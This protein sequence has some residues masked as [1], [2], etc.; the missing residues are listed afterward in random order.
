MPPLGTW[1]ATQ[2]CALTGNR[3]GDLSVRRL[4]LKSSE[5]QQPGQGQDSLVPATPTLSSNVSTS[6]KARLCLG[7][8]DQGERGDAGWRLDA[9]YPKLTLTLQMWRE[10]EGEAEVPLLPQRDS[11]HDLPPSL[12]PIHS[13]HLSFKN[14]CI[15]GFPD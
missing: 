4:A 1:Q 12:N 14:L 6:K 8:Q 7:G 3:T 5:P 13:H 15:S 9:H 2:A 10:W 11:C